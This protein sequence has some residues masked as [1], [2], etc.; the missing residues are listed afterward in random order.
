MKVDI[1]LCTNEKI[2]LYYNKSFI[3]TIYCADSELDITAE[4]IGNY[5]LTIVDGDAFNIFVSRIEIVN[6]TYDEVLEVYEMKDF[7]LRHRE[8]VIDKKGG[9][10]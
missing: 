5:L 1:R 9:D 2:N 4:K 10:K 6:L 7:Q 8:Y 3:G